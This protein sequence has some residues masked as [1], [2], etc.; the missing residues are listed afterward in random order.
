[1]SNK[2]Q[3]SDDRQRQLRQAFGSFV[4]GVTVVTA[5]DADGNPIGFTANSF[6]SV[7]LDP[8]L[9]LVCLA[10]TSANLDHFSR[11]GRFAVNILSE[12]QKDVS[13]RFASKGADRFADTAW[14]ESAEG[15]PLID[16][17]LAW[18]DCCT[19]NLVDAGD[20][21]ILI[22]RVADFGETEGR[23]LAYLRGHYLD[24]GLAEDA[25]DSVSHH[26]GVRVGCLLD[27]NGSV[28]LRKTP[29]GWSLPMGDVCPGFREARRALEKTLADQGIAADLGFL[30]S[31][32][33]APSG[34]AT[35][36]VFQGDMEFGTLD[37]DLQLFPTD[38]LPL[39]EMATPQLRSILR[40]FQSEYVEAR[41]GLYID[42]SN[43]AGQIHAI[44]RSATPW[45]K[46][47]TDQEHVT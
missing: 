5:R 18:F 34:N 14:H 45:T 29:E 21:I 15:T 36:M 43:R 10:E 12:A 24:L 13:N 3:N 46:F 35:W 42:G 22:G 30:Y 11:A 2:T 47:I 41:F 25:A 23:P 44:E 31:V 33:D 32:F 39:Q 16:G 38:Q 28:L 19:D 40:R 20:H 17:A 26:G 37:S 8:A 6:T 1:M 4:T 7:S 27:C 9:L